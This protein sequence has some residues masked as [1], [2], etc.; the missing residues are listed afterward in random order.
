MRLFNNKIEKRK[1][2]PSYLLCPKKSK[3]LATPFSYGS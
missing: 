1:K 3:D 2:K